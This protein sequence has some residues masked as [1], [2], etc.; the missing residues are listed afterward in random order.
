MPVGSELV[1]VAS[2]VTWT[3]ST[4]AIITNVLAGVE[5]RIANYLGRKQPPG[6]L[7]FEDTAYT[8][9]YDGELSDGI[10]LKMTPIVGV[11]SVTLISNNTTSSAYTLTDLTVDGIEIASL[12][13]S[14]ALVGRLQM[15]G[16]SY[17]WDSDYLSSRHVRVPV[18]NF[19]SGRNRI[20]VVYT[21]GWTTI[22]DDLKLAALQACKNV[23]DRK[24][25]S[26]TLASETLG[27]YSYTNVT[28]S[29]SDDTSGP[30]WAFGGVL[31]LLK[32]YQSGAG[33]V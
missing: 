28:S 29:S 14:P 1:S 4:T 10:L 15:R 3:G 22:P 32:P 21:G 19:G 23:V 8:E 7:R 25:V 5:A 30:E 6:V 12:S 20:K 27:N 17:M 26:S 33:L 9:Y 31:D 13:A 16:G 24:E 18:P 2:A 11:T